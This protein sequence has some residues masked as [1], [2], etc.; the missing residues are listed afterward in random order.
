ML[1]GR[2]EAGAERVPVEGGMAKGCPTDVGRS[3]LG[4]GCEAKA[5]LATVPMVACSILQWPG[6]AGRLP[7]P[8]PAS[9][10][11]SSTSGSSVGTSSR[12]SLGADPATKRGVK[13]LAG[14]RPASRAGRQMDTPLPHRPQP[15]QLLR[16][17]AQRGGPCQLA[18]CPSWLCGFKRGA[19]VQLCPQLGK[20]GSSLSH[21]LLHHFLILLK[22]RGD[23]V[24]G[25][26]PMG[27]SRALPCAQW[28]SAGHGRP[29]VRWGTE[30]TQRLYGCEILGEILTCRVR[31]MAGSALVGLGALVSAGEGEVPPLWCQSGRCHPCGCAG[32]DGPKGCQEGTWQ[33]CWALVPGGTVTRGAGAPPSP[34]LPKYLQE[35]P[36]LPR[37][38]LPVWGGHWGAAPC[39]G[40]QRLHPVL[41]LGSHSPKEPC[42]GGRPPGPPP[43]STAGRAQT[44]APWHPSPGQCHPP[45]CAPLVGPGWPCMCPGCRRSRTPML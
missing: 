41:Q 10:S 18:G 8:P 1:W 9:S 15:S 45:P 29:G 14:T 23:R 6:A 21:Q 26:T 19:E 40:P 43:A 22:G 36:R 31:P 25:G 27:H 4:P 42:E 5:R 13:T 24:D 3:A 37:N 35:E 39:H 11:S 17:T 28:Q 44:G 16:L 2:W 7:L 20:E 34:S 32:D 33:N 12:F 30:D 38:L